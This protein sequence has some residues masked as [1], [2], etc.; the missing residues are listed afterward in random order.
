MVGIVYM[1]WHVHWVGRKAPQEPERPEPPAHRPPPPP[2]QRCTAALRY[3][4]NICERVQPTA[5]SW[6]KMR[7]PASVQD[8]VGDA[9][10]LHHLLMYCTG[11]WN[12]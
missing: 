12:P 11:L 9:R 4:C 1:R 3:H 6:Y 10:S 8:I 2:H 7:C 5:C